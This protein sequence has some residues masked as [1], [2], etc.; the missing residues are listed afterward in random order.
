MTISG[1]TFMRNTAKL[2]YPLVESILSI[3]PIVD[4]FVIALGKG[5]DDDITPM[6]LNSIENK[7]IKIIHTL[8]DAAKFPNGTEYAH[9]TDIE[10]E[11]CIVDLLF[12]LKLDELVHE[13]NNTGINVIQQ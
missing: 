12:Y 6:L 1:F 4:E 7:K 11:K 2:Y 13:K 9:Q 8:W 5:D 10:K 3:L